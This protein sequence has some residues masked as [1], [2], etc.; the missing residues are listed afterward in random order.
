[1][2]RFWCFFM[3]KKY[4][5]Y[6]QKNIEN[7]LSESLTPVDP[8]KFTA[9]VQAFL[10]KVGVIVS[11]DSGMVIKKL[12]KLLNYSV[13]NPRLGGILNNKNILIYPAET[14]IGKSV[15]LQHYVAM[16][17]EE[18]SLIVVNTIE[19]AR[20]YC[21]RINSIKVKSG[22]ARFYAGEKTGDS[23]QFIFKPNNSS[24]SVQCLVVTN[25]MFKTLHTGSQHPVEEFKYYRDPL[26]QGLKARDLVVI[27]ERLSFITKYV[28]KF[29]ELKGIGDFLE[30]TLRNS[31]KFKN[32]KN[33]KKHLGSVKAILEVINEEHSTYE[34]KA[35]FIDRLSIE[36]KLEKQSLPNR[37]DFEGLVK[38]VAIRLDE[39]DKEVSLL[40]PS[41]I[42]NLKDIKNGVVKTINT[43]IEVTWLKEDV[44]GV[45]HSGGK[46]VYREFAIYNKDLY[47]VRSIF[48][49]FG[50]AVVLDATA[51]VNSFYDL[52]SNSNSNL[53]IV[54]APKIRK[55][56]NLTIYKAQ[57]YP[58][59]A[60][61]VFKKSP[62]T[63][64]ANASWY[65][66]VI[67][68]ILDDDDK[69][70]V[71]SFKE[72]IAQ[73]LE[74]HFNLDDRVVFT[75]WGKHAGRNAWSDCN[76]VIIIGWL[77]LPEEEAISKLF[78]ISNLGTS[79]IRTI[80]HVTSAKVKELQLSEIADDLIQG[81]M[82]CCARV[83]G[84]KDSDCKEASVYLFQDVLDGSDVVI[85][86][87][88]SQFPKRKI[89]HWDPEAKAPAGTRT[90]PD[91]KKEKAI[92]GLLSLSQE[93]DSYSR[94]T[95]CKEF[96]ISA[97]TMTRWL[98]EGYFKKRLEEAG[99]HIT[100]PDGKPERFVFSK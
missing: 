63:A 31:P 45:T 28:V 79:D 51:Q 58:Q 86:L 56:E 54:E 3:I 97:G 64:K 99:F 83:I 62:Q 9:D 52:S 84:T 22:Y 19:E 95:F 18:S 60:N 80:K 7:G 70:L 12:C 41:K 100:K 78:H 36:N 75:N 65:A 23:N 57:G 39:I 37:I 69:L 76:K 35:S 13:G 11:K 82:R 73:Y 14:G 48:N 55:Y 46:E 2:K 40:K 44:K 6:R 5:E 16:L 4:R 21:E 93:H 77:R 53:D 92:Q 81:A 17:K 50:T 49:E 1:M 30:K 59:S 38:T 72:F 42:S 85:D 34:V 10:N 96:N 32:D 87:F 15:S 66:E 98:K 29:N 26:N 27:D 67:E 68:E 94:S 8:V 61:A 20:S 90:K 47:K 89:V 33:V 74:P 25:K 88:E 24:Q 91:Q 43:F 71:I